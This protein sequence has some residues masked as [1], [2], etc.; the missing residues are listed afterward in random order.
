M[1]DCEEK[2]YFNEIMHYKKFK[3]E[4]SYRGSRD[5]WYYED[6]HRMSDGKGPTV[7]LFK[8]KE[9]NHCIG[10]FTCAEWASFEEDT[11][12]YDSDVMLFN[13]TTKKI[14]KYQ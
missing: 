11:I 6:F 14:F 13:L 4:L 1:N 12:V 2:A 3:T 10:G 9:N 8:I 7:T 5:G